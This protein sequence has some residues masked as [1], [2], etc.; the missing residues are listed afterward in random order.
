MVFPILVA[1]LTIT[2]A[3]VVVVIFV[4]TSRDKG[5]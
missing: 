2:T 3:I 5:E 1:A 4:V